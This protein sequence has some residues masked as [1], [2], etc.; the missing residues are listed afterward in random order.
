[1]G[2]LTLAAPPSSTLSPPPAST[3]PVPILHKV[4]AASAGALL[5]ALLTTPFDVVKTRMQT[6]AAMAASSSGGAPGGVGA[7][8]PAAAAPLSTLA[9]LSA[10]ARA[11]G[12]RS[13]WSGLRPSL[14]MALPATAIYFSLYDELKR[15]VGG[16]GYAPV[17]AGVA[18]RA[19]TVAATAPLE[20]LR[21]VAMYEGGQP[22]AGARQAARAP[23][24]LLPALRAQVRAGG[25]VASLWRGVGPTLWRDVP[26]SGIYWCAYESLREGALARGRAAQRGRPHSAGELLAAAFAAGAL[27]GGL[28]AAV[29]TPFDVVKTRRQVHLLQL[30]ARG[31]RA[32]LGALG[33]RVAPLRGHSTLA[34]AAGI[35]RA[36]GWAG[37]FG[38]WHARVAKVAPSCAILISCYEMGIVALHGG[39]AAAAGGEDEAAVTPCEQ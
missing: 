32:A 6:R 27:A 38:G 11:E 1:M 21:T 12:V 15:R 23:P 17:L 13:L 8:S 14:A 19:I 5:T 28:A 2:T 9:T 31:G 10:L 24:G 35:L 30:E 26:F 37:L 3:Y 36:E 7:G 39:R 22:G 16:G 20:L 4:A 29:T 18:A 33:A 25:G 34:L